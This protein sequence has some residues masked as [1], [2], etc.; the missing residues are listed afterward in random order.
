MT[1]A[2][3]AS[4]KES[5]Q[6]QPLIFSVLPGTNVLLSAADAYFRHC[7]NQPYSL[8]H[9]ETFRRDLVLG[10]VPAH[11]A[12]AFL[13]TSIRFLSDP[14]YTAD[15][16]TWISGYARESW[17][18]IVLSGEGLEKTAGISVVQAL[19]LLAV[20][21][22]TGKPPRSALRDIVPDLTVHQVV[23]VVRGG[24]KVSRLATH[25]WSS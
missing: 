15:K 21:D 3:A 4:I 5:N 11:L 14:A 13:A 9:E 10:I 23:S 16:V 19:I 18:A 8:F 2:G 7:H 12:F 25:F 17:K 22:Y 20:I 6:A 1:W 24:L